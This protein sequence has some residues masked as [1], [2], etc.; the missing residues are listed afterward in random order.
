MSPVYEPL[1]VIVAL[2][3]RHGYLFDGIQPSPNRGGGMMTPRH[4]TAKE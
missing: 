2:S 1:D 3:Q 4:A